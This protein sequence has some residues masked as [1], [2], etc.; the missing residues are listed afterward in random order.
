[1][2]YTRPAKEDAVASYQVLIDD[3][4]H[5]QDESERITHGTFQ[6]AAEA[7]AACQAI[8]DE[9]LIGALKPGMSA[10]A[11]YEVYKSFG[12]DPFVMTVD[13]KDARVPFSAWLYAEERCE[14]LGAKPSTS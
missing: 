6:S 3:N 8:V 2:C 11:L 12:D 7:V 4:F 14:V 10:A 13:P 1:M 9:F 5:Y